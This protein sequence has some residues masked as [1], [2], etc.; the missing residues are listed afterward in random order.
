MERTREQDF[1][2]RSHFGGHSLPSNAAPSDYLF[3]FAQTA[4]DVP[5]DERMGLRVRIWGLNFGFPGMGAVRQVFHSRCPSH[6]RA[7]TRT[8]SCYT[9]LLYHRIDYLLDSDPGPWS[10]SSYSP[11]ESGDS[12][13]PSYLYTDST[14]DNYGTGGE[15]RIL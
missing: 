10:C 9:P 13:V 4:F 14:S 2:N 15:D 5:N 3:L 11:P 7:R 6:G 12:E 1:D 8:P